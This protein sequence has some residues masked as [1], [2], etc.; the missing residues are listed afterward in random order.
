MVN[1]V[2]GCESGS[3]FICQ[4]P[5]VRSSVKK[6]EELA[7]PMSLMHSLI[8]FMEYLSMCECW[9][10]CQKSC[11]ILH[12]QYQP[13]IQGLLDELKIRESRFNKTGPRGFLTKTA[14][15]R[16]CTCLSMAFIFFFLDI[17]ALKIDGAQ[18]VPDSEPKLL[19]SNFVEPSKLQPLFRPSRKYAASTHFIHI[20]VPFNFSQTIPHAGQRSCRNQ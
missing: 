16:F 8:S 12:S 1:A 2:S 11:T 9:F 7:L 5:E 6:I 18:A 17:L 15:P 19:D 3:S 4:N 20:Q 14:T 10:S 13:L